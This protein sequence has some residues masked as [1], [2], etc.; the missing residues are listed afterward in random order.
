MERGAAPKPRD[1]PGVLQSHR[2]DEGALVTSAVRER[3]PPQP[4]RATW[5]LT[6]TRGPRGPAGAAPAVL[7]GGCTTAEPQCGIFGNWGQ[8]EVGPRHQHWLH[9]LAD[10]HTSAGSGWFSHGP[11]EV[12]LL[13]SSLTQGRIA[14]LTCDFCPS[15]Q[16]LGGH[17][18][19]T[20][21]S[22]PTP[23]PADSGAPDPALQGVSLLLM[24]TQCLAFGL[25]A[26]FCS[27][28]VPDPASL[29]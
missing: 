1:G 26:D 12:K 20:V 11:S 8:P 23:G 7:G 25:A 2:G 19:G 15:V 13:I 27:R 5:T 17:V 18:T 4:E 14:A 10:T 16:V 21:T 24:I 29:V 9:L 28:L 6:I 22:A 3:P